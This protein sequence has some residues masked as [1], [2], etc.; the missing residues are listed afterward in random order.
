MGR[1]H[2]PSK[3]RRREERTKGGAALSKTGPHCYIPPF[4]PRSPFP[5]QL[6][7]GPRQQPWWK[8]FPVVLR[9]FRPHSWAPAARAQAAASWRWA[10]CCGLPGLGRDRRPL[11]TELEA[12]AGWKPRRLRLLNVRAKHPT[13]FSPRC[14]NHLAGQVTTK[15]TSLGSFR[16]AVRR[17]ARARLASRGIPGSPA[18]VNFLGVCPE[19]REEAGAAPAGCV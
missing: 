11:L 9:T 10:G 3:C 8:W 16:R 4:P 15:F 18:R 19:G 6:H 1:C 7:S 14:S 17:G 13:L 12:S 5:P 2:L